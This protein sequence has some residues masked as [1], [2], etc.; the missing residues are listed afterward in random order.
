MSDTIYTTYFYIL[1]NS[2]M[3][4][5]KVRVYLTGGKQILQTFKTEADYLTFLLEMKNRHTVK[6]GKH[7]VNFRHIVEYVVDVIEL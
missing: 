5:Y 1:G 6:L 3:K 4:I 2:K 7:I